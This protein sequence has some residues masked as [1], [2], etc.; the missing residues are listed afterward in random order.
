MKQTKEIKEENKIYDRN[1][2]VKQ[3]RDGVLA[4]NKK[5]S[6]TQ[7]S[8]IAKKGWKTRNLTKKEK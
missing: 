4:R 3:G 1:F 7:L 6:K 2:F 5:L 8:E